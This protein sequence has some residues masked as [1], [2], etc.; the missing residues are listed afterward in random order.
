MEGEDMGVTPVKVTFKP[1]PD[2]WEGPTP[3]R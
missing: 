2:G 3:W 1:G